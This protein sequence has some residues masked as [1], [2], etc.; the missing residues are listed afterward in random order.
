MTTATEGHTHTHFVVFKSS[1]IYG[2]WEGSIPCFKINTTV[3]NYPYIN[4]KRALLEHIRL[5]YWSGV[6]FKISMQSG[7]L[8]LCKPL[9]L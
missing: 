3:G 7:N 8:P 2:T 1:C 9:D 4:A 5:C 6:A